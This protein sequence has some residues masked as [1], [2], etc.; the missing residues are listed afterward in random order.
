[1]PHICRQHNPPASG[2][3]CGNFPARSHYPGLPDAYPDDK[4]HGYEWL[5]Q[6]AKPQ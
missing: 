4:S 6:K 1:M 2:I 3:Y 5:Q